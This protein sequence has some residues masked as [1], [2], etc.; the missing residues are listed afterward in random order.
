[1]RGIRD[2]RCV[3]GQKIELGP[4]G[5]IEVSTAGE[6]TPGQQTLM[7]ELCHN[8]AGRGDNFPAGTFGPVVG[9][10]PLDGSVIEV[11]EPRPI[12]EVLTSP[13]HIIETRKTWKLVAEQG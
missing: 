10:N 3:D 8:V 1:M 6:V 4:V 11:E 12:Q 7:Q 13:R 2:D 5:D 9:E